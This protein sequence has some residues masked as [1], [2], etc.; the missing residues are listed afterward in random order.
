MFWWPF[1]QK[2]KQVNIKTEN[3]GVGFKMS[4]GLPMH[5]QLMI[6]QKSPLI[7][8]NSWT[9]NAANTVTSHNWLRGYMPLL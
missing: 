4:V 7:I 1:F 3:A 9:C 5:E 2:V 6:L 8:S